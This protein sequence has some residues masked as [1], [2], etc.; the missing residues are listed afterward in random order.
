MAGATADSARIA[1]MI[2]IH[3]AKIDDIFITLDSHHRNHIAHAVFWTNDANERPHPFQMITADEIERG[4]W[5]PID[6]S[7]KDHCK[8]YSKQLE[9][10]KRFQLTI[11]PEHC[12]IGTPGHAVIESIHR[13]LMEWVAIK[14]RTINYL[15]KGMNCLTEMYSAIAAEVPILSDPETQYNTEFLKELQ[16][17]D[18]LIIGGQAMSHCVQYTV[19]DIV[20]AYRKEERYKIVLLKDGNV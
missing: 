15:M 10:K 3:K 13:S 5:Y 18:R 9:A 7:L 19:R 12:L 8:Y 6:P 4:V 20:T 2:S 16:T 17:A 11:W 1:Q 14:F